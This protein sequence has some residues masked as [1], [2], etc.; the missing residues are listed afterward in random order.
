MRSPL[1]AN[2]S[3]ALRKVPRLTATEERDLV[4]KYR[5]GD[6]WACEK[7]VLSQLRF[8]ISI[9]GRYRRHGCPLADLIQEGTVGLLEAVKRFNPERGTRLSTFAMWWIRAAI[10]D[11]VLQSGSLVRSVTTPKARTMYFSSALQS[12]DLQ[13]DRAVQTAARRF[14]TTTEELRAFVQRFT[15]PDKVIDQSPGND[16]LSQAFSQADPDP[17]ESLA[18]KQQ[19]LTFLWLIRAAIPGMTRRERHILRRRFLGD[20]RA[21]RNKIGKELGLSKERVRQLELRA[22]EKLRAITA[23]THRP[24]SSGGKMPYKPSRV[25]VGSISRSMGANPVIVGE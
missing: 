15:T 24:T 10:Q 2:L 6:K 1:P 17:E 4:A 14:K 9:A 16:H 18:N 3:R 23:A 19:R 21:S 20:K 7:L 8:V 25:G 5:R 12:L 13:N 22:L 11:Y